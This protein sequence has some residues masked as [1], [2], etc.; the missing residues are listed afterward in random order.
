MY[1]KI[2]YAGAVAV[3]SQ[4]YGESVLPMVISDMNCT[5]SEDNLMECQS[6]TDLIMCGP[7]EDAGVVCQGVY[8]CL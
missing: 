3:S 6:E 5:G 4:Y 8:D 2:F 7:L 1:S